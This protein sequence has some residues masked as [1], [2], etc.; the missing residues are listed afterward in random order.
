MARRL[1]CLPRGPDRTS[2]LMKRRKFLK[3]ATGFI[4]NSITGQL[5]KT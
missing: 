3:A 4:A 1:L 2:T 5:A